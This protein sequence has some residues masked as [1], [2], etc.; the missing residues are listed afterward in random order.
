MLSAQFVTL[1][2][3]RPCVAKPGREAGTRDD[4]RCANAKITRLSGV[5]VDVLVKKVRRGQTPASRNGC[6]LTASTQPVVKLPAWFARKAGGMGVH[7]FK[8]D[9]L[10]LVCSAG[11]N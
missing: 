7:F 9:M 2:F 8:T 11:T 5:T 10:K 4:F 6:G 1:L 3:S